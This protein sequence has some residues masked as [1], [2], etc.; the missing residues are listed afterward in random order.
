[1]RRTKVHASDADVCLCDAPGVKGW[2]SPLTVTCP[3]CY[4]DPG[5]LC[6]SQVLGTELPPHRQH[7]ERIALANKE[8]S[9]EG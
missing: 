8:V 7:K 9:R 3:V 1:M 6:W 5:E 2:Q 4:Q